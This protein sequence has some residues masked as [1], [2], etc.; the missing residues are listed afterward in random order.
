MSRKA[1]TLIGLGI[2]VALITGGI[3]FLS[4]YHQYFSLDRAAALKPHP[5]WSQ[6]TGMTDSMFLFWV[7]MIAAFVLVASGLFAEHRAS[8][9]KKEN[10]TSESPSQASPR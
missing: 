3:W 7:A 9:Q 8:I 2:G 5:M 4:D 6:G 10:K 1:R